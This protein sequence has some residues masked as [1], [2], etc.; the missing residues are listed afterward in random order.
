[1]IDEKKIE[2]AARVCGSHFI[3]D[4]EDVAAQQG[5]KK[6]VHFALQEFKK[7]LWH[8][9]SEEPKKEG[10]IL[11]KNARGFYQGDFQNDGK[12]KTY[13]KFFG[14]SQWCYID[15]ILPKEG[16]EE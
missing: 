12:W 6:G 7:S 11:F 1:M 14:I 8:D 3:G 13:A 2:N 9:A 15:D 4:N 10:V 16:G 5:F